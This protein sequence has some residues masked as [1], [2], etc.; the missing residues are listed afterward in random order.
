MTPKDEHTAL[1]KLW[2]E[3]SVRRAIV[4]G[5]SSIASVLAHHHLQLSQKRDVQVSSGS[6][7]AD[8]NDK[9][10][11][12]VIASA[13][14]PNTSIRVTVQ[15]HIDDN[16]TSSG[17]VSRTTPV[18]VIAETGQHFWM[19]HLDC[20]DSHPLSSLAWRQAAS[21]VS[22]RCVAAN[23]RIKRVANG[24]RGPSEPCGFTLTYFTA[25]KG[26]L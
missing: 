9:G 20:L 2:Y 7:D 25:P 17:V 23:S 15:A 8:G 12:V 4:G 26:S 19:K 16:Q 13:H 3:L 1:K 18:V 22:E 11:A 14:Q 6:I 21:R 5:Y 24:R 10:R